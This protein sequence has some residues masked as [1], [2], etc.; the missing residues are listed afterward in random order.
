MFFEIFYRN[1][2]INAGHEFVKRDIQLFMR[3]KKNYITFMQQTIYEEHKCML[4]SNNFWTMRRFWNYFCWFFNQ[5]YGTNADTV[6]DTKTTTIVF[7]DM[8][9]LY[10]AWRHCKGYPVNGQRTW[11]NGKSCTKNNNFLKTYRLKQMQTAFGSRKKSNYAILVQAEAV[12]KLWL[13][14][15]P[16]EWIQG[17]YHAI[18]S[19]SR[20]GSAIPVD[21]A[22]LAKGITTGYRRFGAGERWN[23]SKKALKTV[24]I[25]LPLYFSRFFFGFVRKKYFKYQLTLL[26]PEVKQVHKKKKKLKKKTKAKKKT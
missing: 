16:F 5:K 2:T 21:V 23:N 9:G 7:W 8:L 6:L 22:N 10:K 25:G 26:Q 11:S 19:K 1:T 12:N 15:W 18:R 4:F 24:T 14:T 3:K 13:K 20:K 17:R